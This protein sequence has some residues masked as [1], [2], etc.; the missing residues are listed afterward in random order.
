MSRSIVNLLDKAL[1]GLVISAL[2]A[3]VLALGTG[4]PSASAISPN[5]P[6]VAT[7]SANRPVDIRADQQTYNAVTGESTFLGKVRLTFDNIEITSSKAT[8][9]MGDKGGA[10]LATFHDRPLVR[11]RVPQKSLSP[12][13]AGNEDLLQADWVDLDLGG[14]I[15]RARGN[16]VSTLATI[17]AMP[18]S[19]RADVQQYDTPTGLISASGNVTVKFND[20]VITSG[21]AL[22]RMEA[23]GQAQ[24]VVFIGGS[25]LVQQ[26][27]DIRAERITVTMANNNLVAEGNVKTIVAV[28]DSGGKVLLDSAVQQFDNTANMVL[29]SGSVRMIYED[30][31]AT[32]PKAT[33]RLKPSGTGKTI[34]RVFMTGRPT[35]VDKDRKITANQLIITP[36]PKKFE[37]TGN[38]QTAFKSRPAES[39]PAAPGKPV[40]GKPL[41]PASKAE[42]ASRSQKSRP[43]PTV[44]TEEEELQ[45][46]AQ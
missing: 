8:V 19:V 42:T 5:K 37:A 38:V 36:N 23:G 43:V 4:E 26:G 22:V 32:G 46:G 13:R 25:H 24:R 35:I 12:G 28:P 15:F 6:A 7:P 10:G 45:G 34:D 29:A 33:F 20:T 39:T 17:A 40:K 9:A 30:Y 27:T 18:I 41:K 1:S 14:S 11:H 31:T 21:K 16:V 3:T 44:M 2:L